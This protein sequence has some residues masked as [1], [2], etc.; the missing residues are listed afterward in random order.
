MLYRLGRDR[1]VIRVQRY[2]YAIRS[3]RRHE[4][5]IV[6]DRFANALILNSGRD[7]WTEVKKIRRSGSRVSGAVDGVSNA[8]DIAGLFA[9]K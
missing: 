5:D 4:N 6:N 7:F 3:A 8:S 9:S 1:S 2:Q